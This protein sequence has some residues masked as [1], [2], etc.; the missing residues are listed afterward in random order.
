MYKPFFG[1]SCLI[2]LESKSINVFQFLLNLVPAAAPVRVAAVAAVVVVPGDV[3]DVP[4]GPA[5]V[6]MTE[7]WNG[8][9]LCYIIFT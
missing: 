7:N 6:Q 8:L 9:I 5:V 3:A 4:V 1:P 2:E